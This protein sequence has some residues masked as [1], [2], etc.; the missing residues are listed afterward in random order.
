MQDL[1]TLLSL[2]FSSQRTQASSAQATTKSFRSQPGK[3]V[4][5]GRQGFAILCENIAFALAALLYKAD[6]KAA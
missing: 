4:S 2:R 1:L 5:W 6:H 3:L